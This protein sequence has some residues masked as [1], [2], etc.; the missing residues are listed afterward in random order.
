MNGGVVQGVERRT[1]NPAVA[2]SRLAPRHH[3][4]NKTGCPVLLAPSNRNPVG[5]AKV[6]PDY[7]LVG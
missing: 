1:T 5:P 3:P 6:E 4:V 7:T 2:S